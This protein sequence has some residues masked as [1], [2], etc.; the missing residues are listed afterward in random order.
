M[1]Q[2]MPGLMVLRWLHLTCRLDDNSQLLLGLFDSSYTLFSLL[3]IVMC[4]SPAHSRGK[5]KQ[6]STAMN[7]YCP[8]NFKLFFF[9]KRR[10][11]VLHFIKKENKLSITKGSWAL[12][13]STNIITQGD[14]WPK[15]STCFECLIFE[16]GVSVVSI[17]PSNVNWSGRE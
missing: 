17:M 2:W 5:K 1:I 15:I 7:H 14:T 9:R 12:H 3:N 4:S 13:T 8:H 6:F 11:A 10:R 16:L